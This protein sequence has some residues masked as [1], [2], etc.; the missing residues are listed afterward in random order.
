MADAQ[1]GVVTRKQA[2][3]CGLTDEA[4]W[5]R[6]RSGRWRKPF[7]GVYYTFTGE[8]S[9]VAVLSATLA[10]AGRGAVLSHH[11]A[12]ELLGLVDEPAAPIHISL[13]S[14][15]RP[16]LL[17]GVRFHYR[18]S[19]PAPVPL[20][21]PARTGIND[22][23][24]DLTQ[25]AANLDQAIGWIA[26]A[27]GRRLTTADRLTAVLRSRP[28]VRWRAP[29]LSAVA[30]VGAG[31]RSVLEVRFLR[32][33]ERGHGLPAGQR[34]RPRRAGSTTTYRDVEYEEF[35]LVVELDGRVAHDDECRIRD[36][37]RDNRSATR[38]WATL[39]FGWTDVSER[40]CRTAATVAATL[41]LG[42]WRGP[43]RRCGPDCALPAA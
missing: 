26:R 40:P 17:D 29:L 25:V 30:D 31:S 10:A 18:R 12:A 36:R 9:R 34:Q 6:L 7:R 22:T 23:V 3:E 2:R 24:V 16:Y 38:G 13:P 11:T 4:I 35:G 8:P 15:R 41:R 39:R 20:R 33:V 14:D 43:V 21:S 27:C 37:A 5:A 19:V 1:A 42:G 32:D 28:R